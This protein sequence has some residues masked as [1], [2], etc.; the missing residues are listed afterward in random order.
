MLIIR[1]FALSYLKFRWAQQL[2]AFDKLVFQVS[3]EKHSLIREEPMSIT[4]VCVC[5]DTHRRKLADKF[6]VS[7]RVK[8]KSDISL[9]D[10]I[11]FAH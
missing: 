2:Y 6:S 7:F 4:H 8:R 9:F 10:S 11:I 3:P 5:I 1:F